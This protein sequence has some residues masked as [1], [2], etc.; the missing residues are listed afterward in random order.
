MLSR[1]SLIETALGVLC[2]LAAT[3]AAASLPSNACS[4]TAQ[5][6]SHWALSTGASQYAASINLLITNN[7]SG[8]IPVPWEFS[9]EGVGY[10][11]VV[12]ALNW[13]ATSTSTG[14]INGTASQYWESLLPLGTNTVNLGL[15]I[16]TTSNAS[17]VAPTAVSVAGRTCSLN[18][19]A[20]PGAT[21]AG[22]AI[23]SG[24][25][26]LTTSGG[27]IIGPDG[28]VLN[29]IGLNYFGF[30][31]G[32][33]MLDGLWAGSD[34]LTL[35]FATVVYRIKLLGFNAVRLPF[36]FQNLYN[37]SPKSQTQTCS[38]VTNS[39]ILSSVTIPGKTDIPADQPV[40]QLSN[41]A[42]Q[43]PGVC[44]DYVP[45]D[46]VLNRFAYVVSFLANN[47]FY[48]LLDN[49][50]NLDT[51]VLDDYQQWLQ[52]WPSLVQTVSQDTVAA[53]MLMIDILNEPDCQGLTWTAAN[54]KPGQFAVI[55]K[56][57]CVH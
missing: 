29:L 31:D 45:S 26:G 27:N 55:A 21:P 17:N 38:A 23:E 35:D 3:A 22:G 36:S 15:I 20:T 28:N 44:N 4:V 51:T 57:L 6:S 11:Q 19:T 48:V 12:Q 1:G 37:A 46:T 42:P 40:P 25:S 33:T 54:G 34:Q 7:G 50:F 2:C 43:T 10:S 13:D 8:S 32:N 30:D 9:V 14:V 49:Q 5:V 52:W 41:P 39:A 18:I 16:Q 53:S 24:A 56:L 47:G